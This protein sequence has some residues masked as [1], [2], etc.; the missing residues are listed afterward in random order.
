MKNWKQILY[1]AGTVFF[2]W[3]VLTI[4]DSIDEFLLNT[5][6]FFGGIVFFTMPVIMLIKYIVHYVK[7]RPGAKRLLLWFAGYCIVFLPVWYIIYNAVNNYKFFIPQTGRSGFLNLNGIEYIFYGFSVLLA[8][9]A[10]CIVFHLVF[11]VIQI[12]KKHRKSPEDH[13]NVLQ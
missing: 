3:A 8:F 2:V 13:D 11:F 7:K 10:L 4:A 12:I 5:D 1:G 9:T 6:S